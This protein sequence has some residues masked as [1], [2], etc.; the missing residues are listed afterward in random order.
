MDF[1]APQPFNVEIGPDVEPPVTPHAPMPVIAGAVPVVV[2]V[3][4][5]DRDLYPPPGRGVLPQGR[6]R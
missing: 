6:V 1:L 3:I 5:E 4:T 2:Q